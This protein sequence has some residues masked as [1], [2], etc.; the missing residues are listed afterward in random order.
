MSYLIIQEEKPILL[1]SKKDVIKTVLYI[2]YLLK[3]LKP[4]DNDLDIL[5]E[6]FEFGCYSGKD[7]QTKFF[8]ILLQ[9]ELRNSVASARNKISEFTEKGILYRPFKNAIRF[10]EDFLPNINYNPQKIGFISK[11]THAS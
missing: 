11:V 8:D 1:S 10:N 5:T 2:K 9:K 4:F 7:E 6:L 3:G